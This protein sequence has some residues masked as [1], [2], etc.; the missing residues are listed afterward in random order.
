MPITKPVTFTQSNHDKICLIQNAM[1]PEGDNHYSF[2]DAVDR[3]IT[4][5]KLKSVLPKK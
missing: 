5:C 2:D 4:Q 1:N 3:I